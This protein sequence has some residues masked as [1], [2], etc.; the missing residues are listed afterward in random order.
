MRL[1]DWT[2]KPLQRCVG[3]GFIWT[4]YSCVDFPL[5]EKPVAPL[6]ATPYVGVLICNWSWKS[7]YDG[8]STHGPVLS[9]HLEAALNRMKVLPHKSP[10]IGVTS[11]VD[12]YSSLSSD[13]ATSLAKC[14]AHAI[15]S[16]LIVPNK[17]SECWI[18]ISSLHPHSSGR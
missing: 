5:G 7:L 15:S 10:P 13:M 6:I 1:W 11:N 8:V 4:A 14:A 3:K 12:A 2:G 16:P 9:P 18:H 17:I